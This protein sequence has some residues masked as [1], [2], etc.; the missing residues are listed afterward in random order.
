LCEI[1]IAQEKK[2]TGRWIL[3]GLES[4]RKKKKNYQKMDPDGGGF[5]AS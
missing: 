4:K 5:I 2:N 1:N 3:V